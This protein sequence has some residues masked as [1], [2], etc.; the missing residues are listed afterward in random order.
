MRQ[1]NT[2]QNSPKKHHPCPARVKR[3][4]VSI[5]ADNNAPLYSGASLYSYREMSLVFSLCRVRKHNTPNFPQK[6]KGG[7]SVPMGL[8][9]QPVLG[10]GI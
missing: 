5:L 4:I 2:T 6:V 10:M 3:N 9:A 7:R 1:K 8:A